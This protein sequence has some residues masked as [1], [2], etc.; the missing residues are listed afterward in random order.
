M[1][2]PNGFPKKSPYIRI[3]NHNAEYNVDQFYKDCQSP[4]DT[5]SFIL[6]SKLNEIKTWNPSTSLVNIIIESQ[7]LL[8][9]H[10]PFTKPKSMNSSQGGSWGN[11]SPW[12]NPSTNNS[13]PSSGW[14]SNNNSNNSNNTGW[15]N[16]WGSGG[17][18]SSNNN[19]GWGN[20]NVSNPTWGQNQGWGSPNTNNNWGSNNN[21]PSG[22]GSGGIQKQPPIPFNNTNSVCKF[23]FYPRN[24]C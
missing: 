1:M 9:N 2:L 22:W 14:G 18:N 4:T 23:W 21:Q 17:N 20:T 13:N 16:N 15:V 6:N 11:N 12:Q 8:R 24:C 3:I 19:S 10:F 5:K 7:D